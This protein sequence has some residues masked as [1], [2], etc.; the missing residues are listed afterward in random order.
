VTEI[1]SGSVRLV[2]K[3]GAE[4]VLPADNVVLACGRLPN[5]FLK[6]AL[7]GKV[8]EL[9]AIG[10]CLQPRSIGAAIHEAAYHARQI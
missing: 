8:S 7:Q 3:N 4:E 6:E 5:E 2:D 1:N 10:D 9:C